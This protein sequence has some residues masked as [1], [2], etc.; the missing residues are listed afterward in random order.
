M[1]S[2]RKAYLRL[3]KCSKKPDDSTLTSRVSLR[4][5]PSKS[6]LWLSPP[7]A[8]GESVGLVRARFF[9]VTGSPSSCDLF[10]DSIAFRQD[11]HDGMNDRLGVES[12]IDCLQL[13][14]CSS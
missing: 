8:T 4:I 11:I 13:R 14:Q 12:K 1:A 9:A 6:S 10:R 7:F 2:L 5:C 3:S